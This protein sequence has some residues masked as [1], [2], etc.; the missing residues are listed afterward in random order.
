MTENTFPQ[1]QSQPNPLT[2]T[3]P[4]LTIANRLLMSAALVMMVFYFVVYVVFA[5]NLIQFPF[6][7]DQGE[8]F[9]L[10]DV[11]MFSQGRWPYADIETYPFYG[12][13][14]PPLYHVLLVPFAWLFGP[15]YWYGRL[16]SF[17]TTLIAA[18]AI[19]FAVYRESARADKRYHGLTIAVS[20][21]SGLA[22]LASNIVYHIGPLFR[23]HI[24][25]VMFETLAVVVLAHANEIENTQHR[26]RRLLLGLGLLIAAGYTKQLAAFTAIAALVFLFIRNPRRAIV[27]GIGFALVGAGIFAGITLATDGHWWTQTIVANVK[28]FYP[29]QMRGLLVTFVRTHFW[30]LVLASLMVVYELYFSRMSIYTIWFV[31]ALVFNAMAAGT[32]GAGDSYYATAVAAMS[33]LSGIFAARTLNR[34]WAFNTNYLSRGFVVPLRRFTPQIAAIGLLIIPLF[35]VGYGRGVLHMP[36]EGVF[37]GQVADV[38]GIEDN[39]GY[40]FYDPDGYVT[41]AYAQIGHLTT[42][43]DID[44]GNEI[45]DLINTI[46]ADVPVLSEEAAFSFRTDRDVITNPVVLYILDQVGA[47]DSSELVSMI[48]NQAFG[49]IVLRAQFFPH[50]VNI[51]ITTHYEEDQRIAMNGFDYIIMRP[52][53][54]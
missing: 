38:F 19:G 54:N 12:S 53:Q 31:A 44:A 37:F 20:I 28:D 43:A 33:V 52:R 27:W 41:L 1:T 47:Y 7:Y 39:T 22:F 2:S 13:I 3:L 26:R 45:V 9:E 49:L 25:M 50:V 17:I 32:W 8:G 11:M 40:D 24:S 34:S 46:P 48:E 30:L 6:D 10:V 29:E 35:Y 5:V 15:E 51:A 21:L 14:Y 36:T 18:S 42:Q 23:Q 16:F 4:L